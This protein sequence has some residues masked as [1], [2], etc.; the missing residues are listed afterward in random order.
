MDDSDACAFELVGDSRGKG[1]DHLV[2]ASCDSC[3]VGSDSP[4]DLDAEGFCLSDLI[5][6]IG[7]VEQG[8]RGDA[9]LI[10]TDPSEGGMLEEHYLKAIGGSISSS[11]V[12]CRSPSNDRYIEVLHS[13]SPNCVYIR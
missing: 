13:I 1:L 5:E 11:I 8:L 3:I 2:L 9:T 7:R 6:E 12:S 10:E 4:F